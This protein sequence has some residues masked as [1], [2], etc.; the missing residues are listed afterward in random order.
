MAVNEATRTAAPR[1]GRGP[2]GI[3]PAAMSISAAVLLGLLAWAVLRPS[4]SGDSYWALIWGKELLHGHRP[5][6]DLPGAPSTHP[7]AIGVGALFGL[8]GRT[9]AVGLLDGLA[10]L[11]LGATLVGVFRLGQVVFDTRAAGIAVAAALCNFTLVKVVVSSSFDPV[12]YACVVWAA[13]LV[14]VR[15]RRGVGPL[16]LLGVAG[17]Q[18]PEFW[19]L[20]AA[21]WL[22][23]V[24]RAG[25]RRRAVPLA[26]LA[27]VPVACWV[28][29]DLV[30]ARS[31]G[32]SLTQIQSVNDTVQTS[33]AWPLLQQIADAVRPN[34]RVALIPVALA[35]FA[36]AL[37]AR[38]R[39][40]I[41]PAAIGILGFVALGAFG[42]ADIVVVD[43]FVV[44][45]S[46]M[47]ALFVGYAAAGGLGRPGRAG[48]AW[49]VGGLLA[50]GLLVVAF[51]RQVS[52]VEAI[53][54][55]AKDPRASAAEFRRLL[56]QPVA[57][58][59]LR[60]CTPVWTQV[61]SPE[62]PYLS[63]RSAADYRVALSIP[64]IRGPSITGGGTLPDRGVLLDGLPAVIT[65]DPASRYRLVVPREFS[66][67]GAAGRWTLYAR[68]C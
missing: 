55:V 48:R 44:V 47:A 3:P 28:G 45:P 23:L 38:A 39:A 33:H 37:W 9:G 65:N 52:G 15:P 31:A 67:V 26:L 62:T 10:P 43:R 18:R 21:Y 66:R 24:S 30:V 68:G 7:L 16:V 56:R 29:F 57:G 63:G 17:L 12:A 27:A 22:Y 20:S 25:D 64:T 61:R 50:A 59:L 14:A 4:P 53:R 58:R 2:R 1:P 32:N 35:G 40:T 11:A 19:L 60:H 36:L 54:S 41:L 6:V 51:A 42:L 5:V 46:L 13:V 49:R 34:L 8:T